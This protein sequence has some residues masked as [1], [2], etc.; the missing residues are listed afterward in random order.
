[1]M[2]FSTY[3]PVLSQ[4]LA[5]QSRSFP[6]GIKLVVH[7]WVRLPRPK[8]DLETQ[9]TVGRLRP[10]NLAA[11]TLSFRPFI[12]KDFFG[13]KN[14]PFSPLLFL[15]SCLNLLR[16]RP[17]G[18]QQ[19][20]KDKTSNQRTDFRVLGEKDRVQTQ[21]TRNKQK[22]KSKTKTSQRSRWSTSA[23]APAS[24]DGGGAQP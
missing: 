10:S 7:N 21:D 18:E 14:G 11:R 16:A 1:M 8:R 4:L 9:A 19:K 5:I 22:L 13:L 20:P 2:R 3:D 12:M 6:I 17:N 15:T 24:C 23:D